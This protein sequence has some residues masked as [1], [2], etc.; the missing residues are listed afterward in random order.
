M[1]RWKKNLL[2]LALLSFAVIFA[3]VTPKYHTV[4][5]ASKTTLN[6]KK[7]TLTKGRTL[8]LKV[9]GTKKKVKWSS[10]KK[11]VASVNAKGKVTA[12]SKGKAV[13]TAKVGA[14][15]YRC[16]ITVVLP[17]KETEAAGQKTP[18]TT[19]TPAKSETQITETPAT[20]TPA[21]ETPATE[22]P[23]EPKAVL[24]KEA[25]TKVVDLGYA[26]Y[27]VVAFEEGYDVENCSVAVDGVDITR[28]LTKVTDDGSI[29]KWELTSLN[30]AKL[31][32]TR[33]EDEKAQDVVLS[34]NEKPVAPVVKAQEPMYFLTH[35]AIPTWD[36]HLTN[37]DE[38]GN[39][40][41]D[42]KKTTFDLKETRKEDVKY[43][44]PDAEL[45][46]DTDAD[47]LY[48]VSGNVEILFNYTTQEEKDWFDAIADEGA[49]ALLSNDERLSTL[50]DQL[51]Y[52]KD[53]TEHGENVVGRITIP[54]GQNN[55]YSNGRYK[56][57]IRS[58]GNK[59][60]I[61]SIHVVNA[62]APSMKISE[63]GVIR[64]GM[65]VHFQVENMVYGITV[66]IE[67]VTLKTPSGEVKTLEKIT[68]WY[69]IGD[70]FVL[71]NDVNAEG[72][73]NN[74]E[75]PGVYTLTVYANGFKSMSK[76]FTVAGEATKAEKTAKTYDVV[77]RATS[78]GNTGSGSEGE[79]GSSVMPAN[80]VF[81]EDLLSNAKI[82]VALGVK[83][84]SQKQLQGAGMIRSQ[85]VMPF[86]VKM[87]L[88]SMITQVIMMPFR[89]QN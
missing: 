10:S 6:Y 28:A 34:G 15:E 41:V 52:T 38:E 86:M 55:F 4:S 5:A 57:R 11:K 51:T 7:K 43:Y 89:K 17:K 19:V 60:L 68:D 88:Y 50:N 14:K 87:V 61:A 31:V 77:T 65:N 12:K 80:L 25:Q 81:S 32:V 24:V 71:Y 78:S 56:V 37:Y 42:L 47:N 29:V 76:S 59:T 1:K 75:Q 73:R 13:I 21:T 22:V 64:S 83:N 82:L 20:E 49:L 3:N 39:A 58:N 53:T 35:A 62:Q 46:K 33:M 9:K 27:L 2:V 72:G 84:A 85:H 74:I 30:P 23:E 48:G 40:R 8:K 67:M 54:I 79:S 69:L 45:S 70:T 26:Q 63:T 66:P 36:Y 18:E 16:K 44:A